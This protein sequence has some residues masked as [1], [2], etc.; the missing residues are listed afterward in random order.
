MSN[1][2]EKFRQVSAEIAR[3]QERLKEE[4][5]KSSSRP[6][7]GD[8]FIFKYPETLGIQWAIVGSSQE[9]SQLL[10]VPADNNPMVGS[11]DIG[12]PD[13]AL[14][15]P[16]TLRCGYS[17]S[18]NPEQF[19][20][21]CLR[22]G[23]LEDWDLQYASALIKRISEK[24]VRS[25]VLQ[26]ETDNDP[27]YKHWVEQLSSA[28]EAFTLQPIPHFQTSSTPEPRSVEDKE[29][30]FFQKLIGF[31]NNPLPIT[32]SVF[33]V[34]LLA[35]IISLHFQNESGTQA[36]L[37]TPV[38][39]PT[40]KSLIDT[41]YKM[42]VTYKTADM[43]AELR[44]LAFRWERP[45]A[46][47]HG[48]SPVRPPSPMVSA[49]GAGLLMGREALLGN[50][51]VVLPSLLLPPV[52]D[53][54][55]LKTDWASYFELGR[56]TVLL[57]SVSQSW[58]EMPQGFWDEQREILALLQADFVARQQM[59]SEAQRVVFQ[60]KKIEAYLEKLPAAGE[61][62]EVY[63]DFGFELEGMMVSLAPRASR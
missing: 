26:Q 55:W 58:D 25:S 63:D 7:P 14:S 36:P 33:V 22:V 5:S 46:N 2:L 60:L 57:W 39:E 4:L 56:W 52:P 28:R 62:S 11:K 21:D 12:I 61:D 48:F 16:V 10:V 3:K 59:E 43:E 54:N 24:T 31:F 13:K 9:N 20:K 35:I 18:M 6:Q 19:E 32:A 53:G 45:P 50:S 34:V 1:T 38:S 30:N 41:L 29:P 51:K 42:V 47:V 27:D 15:G 40:P 17:F 37:D 49:F 8:I 44:Q 23:M